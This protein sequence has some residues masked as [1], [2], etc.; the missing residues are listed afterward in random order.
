MPRFCVQFQPFLVVWAIL[1]WLPCAVADDAG[2]SDAAAAQMPDEAPRFDIW[3]IR[4]EGNTLLNRPVIEGVVYPHLGPDKNIN[5]VERAREALEDAYHSAGYGTVLVN[6]PEQDVVGGIVFLEVME[7][8]VER[9]RISGS[10][11]F[12]LGKIRAAVPSL[13]EGQT[14]Y[15]PAVQEEIQKLNAASADRKVTPILKPGRSPGMTDV[16]LAVEDVLPVHGNLELNGRNTRDTT[17]TRLGGGLRYTNLWQA[18][19]SIG[20]QFQIT[21]EDPNE[22]K[23]FSGSYLFPIPNSEALVALYGVVTDSDVFAGSDINVIGAGNIVGA[24]V[25]LPLAPVDWGYHRA[26]FGLDYKDFD[27]SVGLLGSDSFTTPITYHLF[28]AGYSLNRLGDTSDTEFSVAVNFAFRN[29]GNTLKEFENKRFL[30]KPNFAYL[31]A[32]VDHQQYFRNRGHV[33]LAFDGQI[34][35]SPLI[36]NEQFSA[37]GIESV[38]GYVESQHLTDHGLR[39]S[40]EYH[41]PSIASLVWSGL[42]DLH[43]VVFVDGAYL[44]V[45]NALPNQFSSFTLFSAGLG[46]HFD[47]LAKLQGRIYTAWA[48]RQ[49]AGIERGDSRIHFDFDYAF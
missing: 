15:V 2:P 8:Q 41:T 30:A 24:R 39:G 10:R 27:E 22:T 33:R 31:S 16:E 14:P 17:R 40:F 23:V 19:H 44:K 46:L 20:M 37:G 48:L 25:I 13:R 5:T 49:S 21:P 9:L 32:S 47:I 26:S 43:G 38:R 6:I 11:Y 12:A 4:V 35:E 45:M 7:G 42:S 1:A 3:E 29:L 36:S 28:E 34:A 18:G